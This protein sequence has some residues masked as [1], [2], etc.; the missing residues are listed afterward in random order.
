MLIDLERLITLQGLDLELQRLQRIV[1]TEAER[2]AAIQEGIDARQALITRIRERQ[3]E[4][5]TT[6]RAIE[7]DL[8]QVQGRLG[9]YR[10]QLME[11]KTN[12]EYHAMQSEIAT[13]E[14]EVRK[15]EDRL[16]EN[17]VGAD[18]IELELKTARQELATA[19][20]EGRTALQALTDE[21]DAAR[22]RQLAA[23]ATRSELARALPRP[24]LDL[25][26]QIARNRGTAVAQAR[27]GHCTVCHV[28]LRPQVFQ[29]VR[30]NEAIIQCD[31][32]QRILY[33]PPA[34]PNPTG[35]SGR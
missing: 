34:Q 31:S 4:A 20:A 16:L 2:R 1:D 15:F 26:E 17:M 14:S 12:K 19:E 3:A 13:A 25:F 22:Q 29:N 11:V 18:E 35:A 27:D 23:T 9:K 33:F 7:K 32:C 5:Q 8:A 30:R 21:S 24:M 6:R 28:R 10:D